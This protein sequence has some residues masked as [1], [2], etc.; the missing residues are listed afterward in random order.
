LRSGAA[1]LPRPSLLF[2]SVD[3]WCTTGFGYLR[4]ERTF[5]A[6]RRTVLNA[7][8]LLR[9]W[10]KATF[11]WSLVSRQDSWSSGRYRRYLHGLVLYYSVGCNKTTGI[12]RSVRSRYSSYAGSR[13]IS[14]AQS[15]S[16]SSPMASTARTRVVVPPICT[17]ASGCSWRLSHQAGWR[18][19]PAFEPMTTSLSPSS[20]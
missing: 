11:C 6:E 3:F 10:C 18:S 9:H 17:V 8:I 7:S 14:S 5:S 2:S 15:L 12:R 20:K 1:T 19:S 16:R 13:R 4:P